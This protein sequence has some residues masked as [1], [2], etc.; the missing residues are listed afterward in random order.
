MYVSKKWWSMS[1]V[2]IYAICRNTQ[3]IKIRLI[4]YRLSIFPLITKLAVCESNFLWVSLSWNK[5]VYTHHDNWSFHTLYA[6]DYFIST[7][8]DQTQW[9]SSTLMV[10]FSH[11][12]IRMDTWPAGNWLNMFHWLAHMVVA[13]CKRPMGPCTESWRKKITIA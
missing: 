13:Q 12:K 2:E 4:G 9:T 10:F 5:Y 6:N 1:N 7:M 3:T 11:I 8:L